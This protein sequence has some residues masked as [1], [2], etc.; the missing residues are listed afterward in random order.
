MSQYAFDIWNGDTPILLVGGLGSFDIWNVES[1]FIQDSEPTEKTLTFLA[2]GSSTAVVS[3]QAEFQFVSRA[4]GTS[5]ATV[6]MQ[7]TGSVVCLAAGTSTATVSI[8]GILT[9]SM[10]ADGD[11]SAIVSLGGIG[12]MVLAP[13][14]GDST[15]VITE[16]QG[17][18]FGKYPPTLIFGF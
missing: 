9:F 12:S 11:S 14:A 2:A 10:R 7:G 16:I 5:T 17:I 8:I 6:N 3:F 18:P 1:P 13:F 4:D 15:A